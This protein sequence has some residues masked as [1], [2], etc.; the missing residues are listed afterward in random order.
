MLVLSGLHR[1]CS[2]QVKVCFMSTTSNAKKAASP[3][4]SAAKPSPKK[5]TK[6]KSTKT[7]MA[8]AN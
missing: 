5:L 7:K 4:K 2:E 3:K 1:I 8:A 6:G